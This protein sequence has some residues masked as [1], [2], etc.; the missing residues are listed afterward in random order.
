MWLSGSLRPFFV[1]FFYV[2]LPPLLNIFCLSPYLLCPLLSP[3]CMKYSLDSSNFLK[4]ISSLPHCIFFLFFV[5]FTYYKAFLSLLSILW[6]SAI[7]WVYISF[8]PLP[9]ASLPFLALFEASSNDHF[10]LLHFFFLV[11]VLSPPPESVTN[12][13][14]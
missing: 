1:W 2:F 14:P 5:L 3:F 9:F 13:R 8:Y 4:E 6:N 11:M 12:L 7:R 10:A